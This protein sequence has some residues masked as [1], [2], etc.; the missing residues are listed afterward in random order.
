MAHVYLSVCIFETT[1]EIPEGFYIAFPSFMHICRHA[2]H[3]AFVRTS[4]FM[5]HQ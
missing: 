3:T 4:D 2:I 1:E 5:F